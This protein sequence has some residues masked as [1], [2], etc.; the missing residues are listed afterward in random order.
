MYSFR[1]VGAWGAV[2][3]GSVRVH[4]VGRHNGE[5]LRAHVVAAPW[6]DDGVST[7][8]VSLVE[9]DVRGLLM[10]A[11]ML[12]VGKDLAYDALMRQGKLGLATLRAYGGAGA[13]DE[14]EAYVPDGVMA[15]LE[16]TML[17]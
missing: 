13:E 9:E 5:A 8:V 3:R 16:E 1:A 12:N 15:A 6:V 2:P 4:G 17:R 14:G 11:Q 10:S 7:E